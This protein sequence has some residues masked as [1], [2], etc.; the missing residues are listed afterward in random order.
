M[1]IETERRKSDRETLRGTSWQCA[2]RPGCGDWGNRRTGEKPKTYLTLDG[3][4]AGKTGGFFFPPTFSRPSAASREKMD[5]ANGV[6]RS[7]LLCAKIELYIVL[8]PRI[9][10]PRHIHLGPFNV[11]NGHAGI[12]IPKLL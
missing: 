11:G 10:V 9:R 8:S 5:P 3:L 6:C 2:R 12:Q 1:A 4:L 7:K